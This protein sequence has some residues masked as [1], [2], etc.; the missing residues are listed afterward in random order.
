MSAMTRRTFLKASS[1]A[2]APCAFGATMA[3]GLRSQDIDEPRHK[4]GSFTIID[5]HLHLFEDLEEN[6]RIL[7]QCKNA[8]IDKICAFL[9]GGCSTGT[10]A[11]DPNRVAMEL[12]DRHPNDVIAFARADGHDG[13][14]AVEELTRVVEDHDF[15]GLKQSFN[16]KASDPAIFPLVEKTI[17]LRIP[18]LFHTFMDRERRPDR[19]ARNPNE[20]SALELVQLARRYPE[21]VIVMAHYNLGDWEFGLK[22]VRDTPNIYPST[23]GSGLAAGYVE[24]G[25]REVGAERIIFGTDNSIC[26]G[27]AK[28]YNAEITDEER[29]MIFGGNLYKLLTKRG[30]LG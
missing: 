29:R 16:V 9:S 11:D 7:A 2:V 17:D 5:V 15:R 13:P 1:G 30:P 8:G 4:N 10:I 19:L 22:A 25:V 18:I 28:I 3:A 23:G 21:A 24:A 26:G 6:E 20:T 12:H 14:K 27:M